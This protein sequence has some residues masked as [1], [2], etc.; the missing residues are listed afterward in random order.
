ME[1]EEAR[2]FRLDDLPQTIAASTATRIG[3]FNNGTAADPFW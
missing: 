2:F 3:E 1:L